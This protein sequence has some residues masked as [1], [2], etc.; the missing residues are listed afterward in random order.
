MV[1]PF[2][3]S[4]GTRSEAPK[5]S[6]SRSSSSRVPSLIDAKSQRDIKVMK[7]CHDV[8]SVIGEEAL[9]PIRECYNIL[10][11]YV[12]WA[13]SVEQR[14][15]NAGSSEISISVDALVAGLRFSL[16]P[17]PKVVEDLSELDDT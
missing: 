13:P 9:G 12:L 17:T 3:S 6:V 2:A 5:A 8:V 1:V 4:E 16:H 11:E 14:P 7:S 15:Y 10:E